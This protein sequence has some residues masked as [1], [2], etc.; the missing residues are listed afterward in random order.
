MTR[1]WTS[2]VAIRIGLPHGESF[3]RG[4]SFLPHWLLVSL[5]LGLAVLVASRAI[6]ARGQ[7]VHQWGRGR[8]KGWG[9]F[10]GLVLVCASLLVL[11]DGRGFTE[12]FFRQ[13]DFSFL[14]VAQSGL[15]I[16]RQMVLYHNDHLYPLFRLETWILVRIAGP[17]ATVD[18]LVSVFNAMNYA[19]CL[20]VL[21][22][23]C[24][25][26]HELRASRR[27]V[28][29]AALLIWAWPGWGE[30][31]SGYYTLSAYVQIQALGFCACALLVR[32][33][34]TGF[35]VWFASSLVAVSMALG[36]DISGLSAWCGVAILAIAFRHSTAVG[37][38]WSY[39]S[40]LFVILGCY[41]ILSLVVKHPYS[42]RELV[43]NPQGTTAGVSLALGLLRSP[44]S[45]VLELL[46]SLGGLLLSLILP[47][48]LQYYSPVVASSLGVGRALLLIELGVALGAIILTLRPLIRLAP[49][50]RNVVLALGAE[51]AACLGMVVAGRTDYALH[52]PTLIWWSK[53]TVMPVC[54]IWICIVLFWDRIRLAA[55]CTMD[56]RM[57]VLLVLVI[58]PLWL[59]VSYW[60]WEQILFPG[61][62]AYTA[63]G[64]WGNM[65]NA[66]AR[67]HHYKQIT[68]DLEELA[69]PSG[70]GVVELPYPVEWERSFFNLHGVLEW[71]GDVR[72]GGVCYLFGDLLEASPNLALTVHY[73]AIAQLTPEERAR[74]GRYPWLD[75]EGL[76]EHGENINM[77]KGPREAL[78]DGVGK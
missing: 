59:T 2:N 66:D 32:G 14:A 73:R 5:C 67:A 27:A 35:A 40:G 4:Y 23:A 44:A 58:L 12:G 1:D 62:L 26:L 19:A 10:A 17:H 69:L 55:R 24:W 7:A 13:D 70:E 22:A 60:K 63:R 78:N 15:G 61:T 29:L 49:A 38:W 18:R 6:G 37:R 9:D 50:D 42:P 72:E 3:L 75:C 53:Y 30:F 20:G 52:V 74:Y 36:L 47:T 45:A 11:F 25:L 68:R 28:G 33:I 76:Q 51:T 39:L 64:R 46:G 54:W 65:Q 57:G 56:G 16:A 21:L 8:L 71:G 77:A 48:F 31:T 43:Q 34:R 41:G